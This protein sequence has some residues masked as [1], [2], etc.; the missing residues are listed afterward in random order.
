VHLV[1]AAFDCA[2]RWPEDD[3]AVG[4]EGAA[5]LPPMAVRRVS[6]AARRGLAAL[7]TGKR[8]PDSDEDPA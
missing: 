7:S 5:V 4:D 2:L 8:A 6:P 1:C 3:A